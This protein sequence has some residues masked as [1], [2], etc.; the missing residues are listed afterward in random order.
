MKSRKFS[1]A[2]FFMFLKYNYPG[3]TWAIFILIVLGIPGDQLSNRPFLQIPYF[4]KIIHTGLFFILVFLLSRGFLF[5]QKFSFLYRFTIPLVLVIGIAYSGL[6]EL[7]QAFVFKGRTAD[8]NDFIFD[9]VGCFGGV[10]VFLFMKKIKL[11][12]EKNKQLI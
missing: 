8:I 10:Y 9:V 5:Q 2:F 6:T 7:L 4:D 12:K 3:I 1:P 11:I